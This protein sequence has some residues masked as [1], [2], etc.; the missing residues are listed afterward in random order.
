[1][2]PTASASTPLRSWAAP[3]PWPGTLP[4]RWTPMCPDDYD[5]LTSE[6]FRNEFRSGT[7]FTA[8]DGNHGRGVRWARNK[9]GQ[10]AVVHM[11]KGSSKA[12]YDNIA[13]KA[14][15]SPSRTSTTTSVSAWPPPKP[16]RPR[17]RC[18]AGHRLGGLRGNPSWIMQGYG[19]MASEAAEQLRQVEVN[20]PTHLFIQAG[21]VPWQAPSWATSPTCSPTI[22][23]SLSSWKPAPPT[24][25]I[26]ALLAGDGNPALW[27][28][29]FRPIWP[30][31]PAV[32]PT[33]SPGISSATT[34]PPSSPA[35]TGS[36]PAVWPCWA[37]P[38]RAI[39]PSSPVSPA[40]WAMACWPL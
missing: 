2:S 9:L 19:T 37:S 29:I 14:P 18:R 20:R 4:R 24:A 34:F 28:A 6:Q 16:P 15:R 21:V 35:P 32:S 23:P 11:P 26:K 30:V 33:F 13:R 8:T 7:F 31:W 22:P 3:L 39:P 17:G 10:K 1:M 25:C 36:A 40:P 27:R 5:Y 12:R 38:S